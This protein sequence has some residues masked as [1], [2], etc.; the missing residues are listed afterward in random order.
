VSFPGAR[1]VARV[2]GPVL[3]ISATSIREHVRRGESVR[4]LVPGP[5]AEFIARRGLYA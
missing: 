1:G 4:Y 5:V 2:D 3:P